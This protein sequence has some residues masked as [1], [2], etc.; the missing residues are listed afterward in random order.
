VAMP[1]LM[2]GVGCVLGQPYPYLKGESM[3]ILTPT[4][5][6]Y[7]ESIKSKTVQ[8]VIIGIDMYDEHDNLIG[9]LDREFWLNILDM[10]LQQND[11]MKTEWQESLNLVLGDVGSEVLDKLRPAR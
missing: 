1:V 4:E 6:R 7:I 3:R 11:D 2:N 8:G 10:A 5:Q 9:T